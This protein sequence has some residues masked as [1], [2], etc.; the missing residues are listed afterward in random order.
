MGEAIADQADV[1]CPRPGGTAVD[2]AAEGAAAGGRSE[3]TRRRRV[4]VDGVVGVLA[5]RDGRWVLAND[6]EV[7]VLEVLRSRVGARDQLLALAATLNAG[8]IDGSQLRRLNRL[9]DEIADK[10]ACSVRV[11]GEWM[12]PVAYA[13]AFWGDFRGVGWLAWALSAQLDSGLVQMGL[14]GPGVQ[15]LAWASRIAGRGFG[16]DTHWI[17]EMPQG[18]WDR[19]KSGGD[20]LADVAA[21]GDPSTSAKRLTE[22][23]QIGQRSWELL[24]LVLSHPRCPEAV[25]RNIGTDPRAGPTACRRVAQNLN[26]PADVLDHLANSFY[27]EVKITVAVHPSTPLHT[28]ERLVEI[29]DIELRA[30]VARNPRLP[31]S[32]L[33]DLADDAEMVVRSWVAVHAST[34]Q[35]TLQRLLGDRNSRVR[36]YA[37]ENPATAVEAVAA[38]AADRTARVRRAVAWRAGLDAATLDALAGDLKAAVREA[39]ATNAG[40]DAALLERLAQDDDRHVR[41]AVAANPSTPEGVLRALAADD[42][43]WPRMEVAESPATSADLL[44]VL[45]ADV[46]ECVRCG[47]ADNPKTPAEVLEVLAGDSEIVRALVAGNPAVDEALLRSL[48][49]DTDSLVR[50][51]AAEN[52]SL[53]ADVWAVLAEDDSYC[54]RAAAAGGAPARRGHGRAAGVTGGWLRVFGI[55]SK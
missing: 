2:T 43:W 44:A 8:M 46:K 41:A 27:A 21:A 9:L 37:A 18:F 14:A 3:K 40:C 5:L 15:S 34:P 12:A 42:D 52:P 33:E 22:L 30:T 47:V 38:L 23:S 39:A 28:L 25:L 17:T 36:A 4:T 32:V 45:A 49:A 50:A 35:E 7:R 11:P 51:G 20:E 54:V 53:P 1:V 6:L 29:R 48:A 31:A 13:C 24:D 10:L 16:R 55:G 26:T 19:L